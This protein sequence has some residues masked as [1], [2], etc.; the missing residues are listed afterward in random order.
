MA[1]DEIAR[2]GLVLLGCGK[3]GSAML[4]GWLRQ[5]L[6]AE[7]VWVIE[8]RPSDWLKGLAGVHLNVPL[9]QAP[10]VAVVA[11]KPQMMGEALPQLAGLGGG[12]TLVISIAAGTPIARFEE[13]LGA[14][15]PIVRAMPNTPAAIG[16]GITALMGNAAAGEAHMALAEALLSAVGETVRLESEAQMDAVTAVSGSGPAYVFLLIEAMAA[17]GEAEGLAPHLAMRLAKATVAGAG[18]L[19]TVEGAEPPDQLRVNVTSPG[20]TTAAALEV[21]MDPDSGLVPLMRRAIHAA[22][23]RSRELAG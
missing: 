12:A 8:P 16:R 17:A 10:A 14:A 23:E 7:A 1:F 3:M 15:T 21:L 13:V 5:G 9:P 20:G 18:A 4:A 22:A 2:R 6:P 19:A 11:V